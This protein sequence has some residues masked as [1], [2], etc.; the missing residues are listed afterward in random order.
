MNSRA[1]KILIICVLLCCVQMKLWQGKY[2]TVSYTSIAPKED[3]RV[4]NYIVVAYNIREV[5]RYS[6]VIHRFDVMARNEKIGSLE[7]CDRSSEDARFSMLQPDPEYKYVL[8]SG[9]ESTHAL[10]WGITT[11][12]IHRVY[13]DIP[14]YEEVKSDVID[15]L[16]E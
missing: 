7:L 14:N 4:K 5:D 15:V 1:I 2:V 6:N 8:A 16:S 13:K 12:L 3:F 9:A 10:G 11:R